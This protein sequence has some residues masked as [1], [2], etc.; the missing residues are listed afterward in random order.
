M[1]HFIIC[2]LLLLLAFAETPSVGGELDEKEKKI[3]VSVSIV[4]TDLYLVRLSF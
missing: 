2:I 4:I 3:L 1:I